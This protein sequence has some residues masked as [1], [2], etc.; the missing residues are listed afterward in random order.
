MLAWFGHTWWGDGSGGFGPWIGLAWLVFW[1]AVIAGGVYLLR[2]R[3]TGAPPTSSAE[4]VLAERYARGE[5]DEQEY[6][7]RLAVL[8]G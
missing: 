3:A 1:M 8:Q 5:I 4:Q 7:E 6:R 2:R